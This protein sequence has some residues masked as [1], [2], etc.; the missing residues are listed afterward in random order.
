MDEFEERFRGAARARN[1]SR[2]L[3]PLLQSVYSALEDGHVTSINDALEQLI[4]FL[5]TPDGRTD[6]NCCAVDYFFSGMDDDPR[7]RRLPPAVRSFVTSIGGTLH[8]AVYAPHIARNFES[9]PEQLLERI[10]V[11]KR[12]PW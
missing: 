9:L 11:L 4:M 7:V 8:D 3:K 1:V 6:A 10:R 5:V 12:Q 2:E